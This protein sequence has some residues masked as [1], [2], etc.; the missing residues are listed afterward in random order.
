MQN[1]GSD[2]GVFVWRARP[3]AIAKYFRSSILIYPQLK[4]GTHA[5]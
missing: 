1:P 4:V 5:N 3:N 2:A